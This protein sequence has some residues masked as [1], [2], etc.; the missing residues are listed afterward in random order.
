[1]K[2]KTKPAPRPVFAQMRAADYNALS[3]PASA[4]K[5]AEAVA[6]L[7][8]RARLKDAQPPDPQ[9]SPTVPPARQN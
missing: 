2:P 8:R 6:E 3:R 7:E 4:Q 1:M 5:K 9:Q